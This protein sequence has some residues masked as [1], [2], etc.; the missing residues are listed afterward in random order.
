MP[1]TLIIEHKLEADSLCQIRKIIKEEIISA[2]KAENLEKILN[3]KAVM[4]KYSVVKL[5]VTNWEKRGLKFEAIGG[6]HYYRMSDIEK[7]KES[8]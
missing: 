4:K 7:F 8:K 6:R 5:T 2:R 1:Q 3:R